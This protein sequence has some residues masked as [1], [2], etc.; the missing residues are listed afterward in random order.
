MNSKVDPAKV[1]GEVKQKVKF[2]GQQASD[3][4]LRPEQVCL[5]TSQSISHSSL[6]QWER[7]T[8]GHHN[9][10]EIVQDGSSLMNHVQTQINWVSIHTS[11]P[12]FVKLCM[13]LADDAGS[14]AVSTVGAG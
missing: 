2:Y 1:D 13:I 5:E 11:P 6:K 10:E 8:C 12:S 9:L 14:P 3:T 7:E 4:M